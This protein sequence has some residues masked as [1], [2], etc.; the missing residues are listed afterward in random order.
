MDEEAL[1]RVVEA[2]EDV[3]DM[4]FLGAE[5]GDEQI[6]V[7]VSGR[8]DD[9]PGVLDPD[10]F[11]VLSRGAIPDG[12]DARKLLVEARKGGFVRIHDEN[13]ISLSG[14]LVRDG[15]TEPSAA[16]DY[17]FVFHPSLLRPILYIGFQR[18]QISKW[19]ER[20]PHL[21]FRGP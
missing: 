2:D 18:W 19:A 4:V 5:I 7:V 16:D 3:G 10:F 8:D 15:G 6:D 11:E 14:I 13:V 1:I 17:D 9:F 21:D 20:F 12:K